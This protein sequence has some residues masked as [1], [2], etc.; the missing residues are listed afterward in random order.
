MVDDDHM[1]DGSPESGVARSSSHGRD[2]A[3]LGTR[4]CLAESDTVL[5]VR[6]EDNGVMVAAWGGEEERKEEGILNK[7]GVWRRKKIQTLA[8]SEINCVLYVIGPQGV[9]FRSWAYQTRDGQ[10][11]VPERDACS[12]YVSSTV[13]LNFNIKITKV[14]T[15]IK[16]TVTSADGAGFALVMFIAGSVALLGLKG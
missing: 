13:I 7:A 9:D 4:C 15:N 16:G 2:E 14:V 12:S 6:E 1:G 11:S 3:D 8:S 5:R 10:K